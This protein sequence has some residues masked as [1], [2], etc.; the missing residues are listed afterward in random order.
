LHYLRV[1]R[2]GLSRQRNHAVAFCRSLGVGVVHFIDDDTEILPGYLDALERRLDREPD[3]LGV[4][5]RLQSARNVTDRSR[6]LRSWFLLSGKPLCV[7]PSGI[8][9]GEHPAYPTEGRVQ[10]LSGYGMSYRMEAFERNLFD[11]RLGAGLAGYG[12][13]EDLDFGFRVSR[14][15]GLVVEP[16]AQCLHHVAPSN[17][18]NPHQRGRDRTVH[19][20]VWVRENRRYG[21]KLPAFW[22]SVLGE[23]L[24]LIASGVCRRDRQCLE[25]AGGILAGVTSIARDRHDYALGRT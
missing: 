17:R 21:M 11:E 4:G 3:L 24:L 2:P 12:L 23:L 6:H 8:G 5:G 25:M 16:A 19:R 22:W 15:G 13:G 10:W 20:Y 9:H 14:L 18:S 1:D 7:L